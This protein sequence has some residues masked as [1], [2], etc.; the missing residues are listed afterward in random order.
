[1]HDGVGDHALALADLGTS[2]FELGFHEQHHGAP[3]LAQRHERRDD[4]RE[5]DERQIA[6]DEVDRA[7][8]FRSAVA[9]RTLQRS[10]LVTRGSARS[11]SWSW[12]WPTSSATTWAAP[13]CSRQSVNP[14]VDAPASSARTPVTSTLEHVE[15]VIELLGAA[16][17]EPC[18]R[19]GDHEGIAGGDLT[20]RLVGDRAVHEHAVV[21]D[22]GLGLGS[23]ADELPPEEFGV[24]PTPGS[25][26][27]FRNRRSEP[28]PA[29]REP[30]SLPSSWPGPSS[31][32]PSWRGPSSPGP[33]WRRPS[34]LRSSWLRPSSPAAFLA[35]AFFA[36]AFLAG[37]FLAGAFLAGARHGARGDD[38]HR[39]PRRPV[40]E[41]LGERL[42]AVLEF[43]EALRHPSDLL[44]DLTLHVGRDPLG[45]LAPSI[46]ELL[47]DG[48][49]V[50]LLDVA[51]LDELFDERVG[52]LASHLRELHAGVDQLL[53][54]RNLHRPMLLLS[55]NA[56]IV[57]PGDG[58]RLIV[59]R[60]DWQS[61][62][63]VT[64][65]RDLA[66][67]DAVRRDCIDA[68]DATPPRSA[69]RHRSRSGRRSPRAPIASSPA[70]ARHTPSG[71][72]SS[73]RSTPTTTATTSRRPTHDSEFDE[74]LAVAPSWSTSP[75]PTTGAHARI[76][77]RAGRTCALWSD[78]TCCSHC[79]TANRARP[80]RHG[81]DRP[82]GT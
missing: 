82:G 33:S 35:G 30:S 63:G 39:G 24:E 37:A 36:G 58:G 8:R 49:G 79:G 5:R 73:S 61:R 62:V 34:W 11:R 70:R 4:H 16:A 43:V 22:Q 28:P 71:W 74:L 67:P 14:P 53:N 19:A 2:R 25:H 9:W 31:P 3:R 18:G 80:R 50:A 23:A 38:G 81:R 40:G 65:H 29:R 60:L 55:R 52:L 57:R 54:A 15:G 78:A 56:R 10:R 76:R 77:L 6:D 64:G 59:A 48:L 66:D 7:R 20:R 51:G 46:D 47:H 32:Q 13:R 72:S 12:P 27:R 69:R 45:R 21:G 41:L 1:M 17:H 42:E 68:I 26:R 75:G 44:G